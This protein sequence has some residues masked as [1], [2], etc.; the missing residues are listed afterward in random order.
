MS[1]ALCLCVSVVRY[2]LEKNNHRDTEAQ[3][4]P[5]VLKLSRKYLSLEELLNE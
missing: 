4:R 5:F 1:S 3:S 2:F